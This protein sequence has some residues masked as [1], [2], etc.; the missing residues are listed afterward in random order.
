MSL[1]VAILAGGLASRL[2]SLT[3]VT[4]K[5]LL[6]VAGRPFIEHQIGLLQQAGLTDIVLLVGH[7]GNRIVDV[8]GD[9]S[10]LDVSVRYVFDGPVARGTGGA[11]AQALP[12]LGD[13]FFVLY[14]DS[15]L[16][17]DYRSIEAA[18]RASGCTALMTV[19]CNDNQWDRSNVL[20][21]DGRITAYD[22]VSGVP[23]MRHVEYGLGA[24]RASAFHARHDLTFDLASVYQDC[25][26]AGQLAVFEVASRFYEIGSP[27]GLEATRHHIA[28]IEGSV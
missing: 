13:D 20:L 11:I 27:S 5:A 4:P 7:L 8:V 18:F 19:C 17:C 3:Q 24:F 6:D 26:A 10:R 28:R 12:A 16:E 22:K 2:G 14:G 9:G 23:G 21:E 15:Y 25:L 1:P